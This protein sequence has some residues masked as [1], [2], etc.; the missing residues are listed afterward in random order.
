MIIRNTVFFF[1]IL[2]PRKFTE[3]RGINTVINT[4][5]SI[6]TFK[7]QKRQTP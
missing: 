1:I 6:H 4:W 5:L 7:L 2:S 3:N